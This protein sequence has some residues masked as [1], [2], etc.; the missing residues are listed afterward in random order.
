MVCGMSFSFGH[1]AKLDLSLQFHSCG[2]QYLSQDFCQFLKSLPLRNE[3][4]PASILTLSHSLFF[5]KKLS[6]THD[7][8]KLV[9]LMNIYK[10]WGRNHINTAQPSTISQLP[11]SHSLL[12]PQSPASNHYSDLIIYYCPNQNIL[13]LK[14]DATNNT[15]E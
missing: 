15:L 6:H 8:M 5:L 12:P 14:E 3:P 13:K 4:I 9:T 7:F 2:I 10:I 1:P 11:S